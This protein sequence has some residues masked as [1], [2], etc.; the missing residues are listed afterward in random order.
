M[1]VWE[2]DKSRVVLKVKFFIDGSIFLKFSKVL[3][4]FLG[5]RL[6]YLF[7]LFEKEFIGGNL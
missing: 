3:L 4:F 5:K 2:L 7:D 6:L 1:L